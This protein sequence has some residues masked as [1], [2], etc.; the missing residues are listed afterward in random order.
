MKEKQLND[1][2]HSPS[3]KPDKWPFADIGRHP[4]WNSETARAA[5]LKGAGVMSE[6]RS[7][8]QS[9]KNRKWCEPGCP[10]FIRCPFVGMSRTKYEGRCALKRQDERIQGNTVDLLMNKDKML[11]VMLRTL[12]DMNWETL[13]SF[14][15]KSVFFDKVLALYQAIHGVKS[16]IEV[17]KRDYKFVVE[18]RKAVVEVRKE[19]KE[20]PESINTS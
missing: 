14:R 7:V 13:G 19:E 15:N 18:V 9:L 12:A 2:K 10:L 4:P 8:A 6:R 11:D 5:Q 3:H 20:N 17:E 16:K 1:M